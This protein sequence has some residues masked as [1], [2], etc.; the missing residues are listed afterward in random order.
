M[1]AMD[2]QGGL[3]DDEDAQLG[4]FDVSS[5]REPAGGRGRTEQLLDRAIAWGE[6]DG[7]LEQQDAGLVGGARVAARALDAAEKLGG[8]GSVYAVSALLTPYRELLAAL[9]LPAPTE[10][11]GSK[12]LGAEAQ[13]WMEREFGTPGA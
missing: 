6:K 11:V 9:R 1:S 5:D 10:G 3:F 2:S 13:A 8:K 7:P 4:L 12:S